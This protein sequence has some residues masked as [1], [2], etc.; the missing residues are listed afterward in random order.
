M[1]W[2]YLSL[3]HRLGLGFR[4]YVIGDFV[5]CFSTTALLILSH[6]CRSQLLLNL[7][8]GILL[9]KASTYLLTNVNVLVVTDDISCWPSNR[10]LLLF[11]LWSM[12][13]PPSDFRHAVMTPAMLLMSEY[14][15]RCPVKSG[16]DIAVGTFICSLL[17]SVSESL[18]YLLNMP[19]ILC[20]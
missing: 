16:H 5:H 13:F 17:L 10:T 12:I 9:R 6:Y 8:K 4:G 18:F 3:S 15:L 7:R 20:L 1:R 14:L 2:Y 19:A 11:R